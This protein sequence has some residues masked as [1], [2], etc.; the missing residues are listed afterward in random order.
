MLCLRSQFVFRLAVARAGVPLPTIVEVLIM[1]LAFQIIKEAGL[2][3]PQPIGGAMSIVSGLILGD[4]VVGAGIASR[5]TI[6]IV[7]L[8]TISYFLIPKLYGPVSL[9][10]LIITI[11]SACFGLPGFFTASI[12]YVARLSDLKTGEY[13][14]LFP[15][16]SID[17]YKFKDIFFRGDLKKISKK[18]IGQ[19]G[20]DSNEKKS[21]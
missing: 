3:L 12:V 1:M 8:S 15:L 18:I 4:A 19:G 13:A 21:S 10:S 6:I 11:V 17:T 2:R 7:A 16:G 9:W 5:I 14:Y 20:E